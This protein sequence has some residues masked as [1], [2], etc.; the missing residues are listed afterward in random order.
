MRPRIGIEVD[1]EM[2]SEIRHMREV[3]KK[4]MQAIIS[5]LKLGIS[6]I[7]LKRALV[8]VGYTFPPVSRKGQQHHRL[9]PRP[10]TG[11]AHYKAPLAAPKGVPALPVRTHFINPPTKAQ[12]MGGR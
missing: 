6:C 3:E 10:A 2:L 1:D 12:L 4:S 11:P 5:E 9:R 7:T 8:R